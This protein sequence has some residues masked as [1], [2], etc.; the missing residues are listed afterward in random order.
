M[1][2]ITLLLVAVVILALG[3]ASSFSIPNHIRLQPLSVLQ[4]P[5]PTNQGPHPVLKSSTAGRRTELD[6]WAAA[7]F[8]HSP[9]ANRPPYFR[10]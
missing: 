10:F 6:P 2:G 5:L 7:F 4:R 8:V 9:R 3:S 1:K